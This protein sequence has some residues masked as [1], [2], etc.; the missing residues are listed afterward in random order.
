[1]KEDEVKKQTSEPENELDRLKRE[2]QEYLNG[3]KRAKADLINSQREEEKRIQE[4]R[5]FANNSFA[6]DLL[7]VLDSFQLAQVS[8]GG[9]EEAKKG[10]LLI[11]SQ[12]EDVLKRHDIERIAVKKG[13]EL[14]V[15]MHEVLQEVPLS[16]EEA[17]YEGK[18]VQE[19][20]AGYQ[21]HGR[22]IRAAKVAVGTIKK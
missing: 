14:D 21:T 1:M 11:Q 2:N 3:W 19:L 16:K 5:I 18:I 6:R 13:D 17:M 8:L 15:A 20:F 10:F 7:A 9:S 12:L 22:V 4:A